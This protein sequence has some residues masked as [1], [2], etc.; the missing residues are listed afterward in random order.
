MTSEIEC[1]VLFG[2]GMPLGRCLCAGPV[3]IPEGA[4]AVS[5]GLRPGPFG[6][7]TDEA[8]HISLLMTNALGF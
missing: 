7:Q 1:I 3:A 6:V 5:E 4:E 2:Q 8:S